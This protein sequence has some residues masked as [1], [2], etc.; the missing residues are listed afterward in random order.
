MWAFVHLV[1]QALVFNVMFC[2]EQNLCSLDDLNRFHQRFR[3][4][5]RRER[6][7]LP[8]HFIEAVNDIVWPAGVV[9]GRFGIIDLVS[10]VSDRCSCPLEQPSPLGLV[11]RSTSLAARINSEMKLLVMAG[12]S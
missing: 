5:L 1:N 3:D 6:F 2:I 4:L 11:R 7:D 10:I 9:R 8:R 12:I